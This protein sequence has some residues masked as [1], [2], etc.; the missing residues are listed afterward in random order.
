[1]NKK[2]YL[3]V[4]L[5]L[6]ALIFSPSTAFSSSLQRDSIPIKLALNICPIAIEKYSD[7]NE[8][9]N[10]IRGYRD[11]YKF[12]LTKLNIPKHYYSSID[13]EKS[14]YAKGYRLGRSQGFQDIKKNSPR[15]GFPDFGYKPVNNLKGKLQFNFERSEFVTSGGETYCVELSGGIRKNIRKEE[16]IVTGYL[17]PEGIYGHM[18]RFKKELIIISIDKNRK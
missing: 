9:V 11:G 4:S 5:T 14:P 3:V 13:K 16:V 8:Q 12:A 15:C 1:M 10:F 18:G 6:I 2:K 17:S 7:P